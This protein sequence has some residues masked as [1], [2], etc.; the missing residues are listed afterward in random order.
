MNMKH[1]QTYEVK[2]IGG[3]CVEC[4]IY[5]KYWLDNANNY[6]CLN[7]QCFKTRDRYM[8][9]LNFKRCVNGLLEELVENIRVFLPE[10]VD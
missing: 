9:F 1:G 7:D 8:E 10:E 5:T 4:F 2:E 3:K 6:F